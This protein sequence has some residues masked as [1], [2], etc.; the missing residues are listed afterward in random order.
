MIAEVIS[1]GF[2]CVKHTVCVL[3]R[4]SVRLDSEF[5]SKPNYKYNN[6]EIWGK[7]ELSLLSIYWQEC[8]KHPVQLYALANLPN[9][10]ST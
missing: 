5:T 9:Y 4:I 2:D 10:V 1:K 3:S 6:I 7:G 8:T